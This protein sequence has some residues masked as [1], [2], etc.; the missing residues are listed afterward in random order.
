MSGECE[1]FHEH[2]LECKCKKPSHYCCPF[3]NK[4][5]VCISIPDSNKYFHLI[6]FDGSRLVVEYCPFC[7]MK[8][9]DH[10]NV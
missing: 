4:A 2:C 6:L 9:E 5:F 7:G 10:R 8:A 3:P 1:R